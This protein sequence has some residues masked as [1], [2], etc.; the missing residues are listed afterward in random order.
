MASAT[1]PRPGRDAVTHKEHREV[2]N[3]MNR[4]G[5]AGSLPSPIAPSTA[6]SIFSVMA[7]DLPPVV[8]SITSVALSTA[9]LTC[10]PCSVRRSF[11]LS[12]R[13]SRESMSVPFRWV[14]R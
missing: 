1:S 3:R 12:A 14:V 6:E 10:S 13:P 8:S 4:S 2:P 9:S 7:S 5:Q 11:A